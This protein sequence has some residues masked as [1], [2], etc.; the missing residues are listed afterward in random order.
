V[1][2]SRRG[3]AYFAV[4]SET[5]SAAEMTRRIGAEPD[6]STVRG[7]R[8]VSPT[9]VPRTHAWDLLPR[10]EAEGTIEEQ[11]RDVLDRVRSHE[12]PI[13]ELCAD[14]ECGS[15]LRIVREFRLTTEGADTLGLALDAQDVALL[16][17]V[18]A[19]IDISEYDLSAD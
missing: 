19:F 13:A 16:A 11:L 7:S 17:R 15:V 8:F 18:G 9:V 5:V 4:Y 2:L 14:G 6:R 10:A 12:A 1:S 3:S